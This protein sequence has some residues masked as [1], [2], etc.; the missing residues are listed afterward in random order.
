MSSVYWAHKISSYDYV[1][2]TPMKTTAKEEKKTQK[3]AARQQMQM[4][5]RKKYKWKKEPTKKMKIYM[6]G[7]VNDIKAPCPPESTSHL[8]V[9]DT[10]LIAKQKRKLNRHTIHFIRES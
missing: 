3:V 2:D 4:K 9:P 10:Y 7:A 6:P 1:N 5:G 8:L